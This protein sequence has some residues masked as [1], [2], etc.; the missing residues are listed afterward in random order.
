MFLDTDDNPQTSGS[1][2]MVDDDDKTLTLRVDVQTG[3]QLRGEVIA[4][5]MIQAR[6]VGDVS[7]INIETTPID[8]TPY[9]GPR[10]DFE[11]RVQTPSTLVYDP[12]VWI[13]HLEPS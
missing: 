4:G 6:H 1:I 7:W 10:E 5:A 3:Y 11:I 8:L 12:M 9:S 13:L 2:V